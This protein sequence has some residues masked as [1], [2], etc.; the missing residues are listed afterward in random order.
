MDTSDY[1][2]SSILDLLDK[3]TQ[4]DDKHKGR[5]DQGTTQL[6][7]TTVEYKNLDEQFLVNVR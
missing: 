3:H 5:L 1:I 6:N 4:S 7:D 2:T